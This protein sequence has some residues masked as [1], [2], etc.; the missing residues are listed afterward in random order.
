MT[1]LQ[2]ISPI[3]GSVFAT[4]ET[5]D[6]AAAFAAAGRARSSLSRWSASSPGPPC[7]RTQQ[8]ARRRQCL[9]MRMT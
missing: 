8:A 4:R 5:L 2:C 7:Q 6:E 9:R 1:T 3:D